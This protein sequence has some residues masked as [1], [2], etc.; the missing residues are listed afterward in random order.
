[1]AKKIS[2]MDDETV[3][4]IVCELVDFC[5]GVGIWNAVTTHMEEVG[6]PEFERALDLFRKRCGR[7]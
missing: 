7:G 4:E 3:D 6:Y 1:M 5:G 2:A